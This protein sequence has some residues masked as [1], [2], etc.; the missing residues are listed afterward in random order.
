M[1]AVG[2]EPKRKRFY[3]C[4]S[5]FIIRPANSCR[6][7][8]LFA[9]E[10]RANA[11]YINYMSFVT[12]DHVLTQFSR[13]PAKDVQKRIS[14]PFS[15]QDKRSKER[16]SIVFRSNGEIVT[17]SNEIQSYL[18]QNIVGES[19]LKDGVKYF[20]CAQTVN[21]IRTLTV[22]ESQLTGKLV[23]K[24]TLDDFFAFI[25]L[26]DVLI[27]FFMRM[28]FFNSEKHKQKNEDYIRK[29]KKKLEAY[30]ED[31]IKQKSQLSIRNRRIHS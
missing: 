26:N 31:G 14:N 16:K 25:K 13:I 9:E 17:Q 23:K 7:Y 4:G 6:E 19:E 3:D 24:F 5:W 2:R 18:D 29:S 11:D 10:R 27:D 12:N 22:L 28:N 30:A 20:I 1:I 8:T 21:Q 15:S